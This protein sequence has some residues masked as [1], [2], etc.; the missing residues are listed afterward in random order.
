MMVIDT[1]ALPAIEIVPFNEEHLVL[2][3]HGYERADVVP[4]VIE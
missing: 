1:S 4:V 2:A 3:H